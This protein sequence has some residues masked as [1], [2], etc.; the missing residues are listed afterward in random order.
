MKRLFVR[1]FR[2]PSVGYTTQLSYLNRW[3]ERFIVHE[4]G[5]ITIKRMSKHLRA[6]TA[7]RLQGT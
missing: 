5:M 1:T 2:P 6:R 7:G 4:Q 3:T